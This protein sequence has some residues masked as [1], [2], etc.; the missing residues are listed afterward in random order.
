[1]NQVNVA[2][3]GVLGC[4]ILF[5]ALCAGA[6]ADEQLIRKNLAA[7]MPQLPRIDEVVRTSVAGLYEVRTGHDI[8]YT[9]EQGNF[10]VQGTILDTRTQV[11]LTEERIGKLT[12]IDFARL[13]LADALVIKQGTGRRKLAVFVDPRCGYCKSFERELAEARDVTIYTFLYPVLGPQSSAMARDIW[14]AADKAAAW[15]AWMIGDKVPL[16]AMGKCDDA[17][18][19][20]NLAFGSK[21]RVR[22]TPGV[23]FEDGMRVPGAMNLDALERR[24][25]AAA[26][27][28]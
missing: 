3:R 16:K 5:G 20:R 12:A 24:L 13:P 6:W 1:M 18:L 25:T 14:C 11:D 21:H 22:G 23:V 26:K 27:R 28:T 7:R 4:V 2:L 10:L 17:A 19:Q 15:R 8:Q 9:D